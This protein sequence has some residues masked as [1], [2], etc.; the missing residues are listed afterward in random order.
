[1][2]EAEDLHAFVKVDQS[3]GHIVQAKE[4]FMTAIKI[5]RGQ[6]GAMQLLIEC[7]PETRANVEQ[8]EKARRVESA[9]MSKPRADEVIVMGRDRFQ[10]VKQADGRLN[11]L[12]GT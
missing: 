2:M 12:I 8:R 6:A 1:M 5:V 9:A 4:F 10:N 11:H 3:F 7:V